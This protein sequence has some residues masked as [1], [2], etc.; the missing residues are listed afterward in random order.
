MAKVRA[1]YWIIRFR[2]I[3]SSVRNKCMGCRRLEGKVQ[4]QIMGSLKPSPPWTYVGCDLFGPFRV[5]LNCLVTR[6]LHL[7]LAVDYS[8]GAVQKIFR[9]FSAIR[10]YPAEVFMDCG[11]Q[12][13]AMHE[14]LK[15]LSLEYNV[16]WT[17]STP[18]APWQNGV[19]ESLIKGIKNQG[20]TREAL[21]P[22]LRH[23]PVIRSGIKGHHC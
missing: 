7:D 13:A 5:I 23:N 2:R 20:R 15:K 16:K 18:D 10:G 4:E 17:Y 22:L 11:S 12:L 19:T 6:A 1:K 9:R 14:T 8:E 21:S 3:V